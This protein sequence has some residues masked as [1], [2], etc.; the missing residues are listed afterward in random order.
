MKE[1]ILEIKKM[2]KKF[3][4]IVALKDVDLQIRRGQ[5]PIFNT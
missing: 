1:L 4:P 3:G 2:S 5:I